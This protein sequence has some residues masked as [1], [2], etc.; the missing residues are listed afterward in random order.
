MNLTGR[1]RRKDWKTVLIKEWKAVDLENI[2]S[3]QY[4]DGRRERERENQNC[5]KLFIGD[6]ARDNHSPGPVFRGDIPNERE[7]PTSTLARYVS[8]ETDLFVNELFNRFIVDVR[9]TSPLRAR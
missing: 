7:G 6:M 4:V 5:S 1:C 9:I 3:G 2:T 8:T